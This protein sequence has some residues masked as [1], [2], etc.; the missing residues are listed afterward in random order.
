MPSHEPTKRELTLVEVSPRDG[1]QSIKEVLSDDIKVKFILDLIASGHKNIEVGS[2]VSPK[3]IPQMANTESIIQKV[4]QHTHVKDLNLIALV[5]NEK[6]LERAM[7][8]ELNTVAFVMSSSESFNK[9]NFG[10]SRND[11]LKAYLK[12]SNRARKNGLSIR[13]YMSTI[14]KC[15]YEGNITREQFGQISKKSIESIQPDQFVLSDTT[16]SLKPKEITELIHQSFDFIT[17]DKIGLHLHDPYGIAMCHIKEA[18]DVGIR[19]FDMSAA[20][21]GGC[22]NAPFSTGNIASEELIHFIEQSGFQTGIDLKQHIHATRELI[23]N[24]EFKSI[25]KAFHNSLLVL[26]EGEP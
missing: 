17:I 5:G 21:L 24:F 19:I 13:L 6:G 12:M 4:R 22:P 18:L 1:L 8:C 10:S 9:K 2:F 11:S 20:G 26:N 14:N 23:S 3:I 15:P 25:S 16:G 7:N